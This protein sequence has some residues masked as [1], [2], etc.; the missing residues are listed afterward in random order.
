MADQDQSL[1]AFIIKHM[2]TDHTRSLSL[3]LRAYCTISSRASQSPT[4][5][6]I[7]L[8]DM[9]I[10]AQ[11]SR[12]TIPFDPPLQS[13]SETRA[14]VVAMHKDSL[15]RLGLSD[16]T[17]TEYVPPQGAQY[18]G[19]VIVLAAMVGYSRQGNFLPGALLYESVGLARFP[20]FTE[21][22]YKYQPWVIGALVV[23]HSFE[24]AVL[25]GW[26]RLR[27]HGVRLFS[28]LWWTWILLGFLEGA[29]AWRRFDKL[30]K[31]KEEGEHAKAA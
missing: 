3:Y 15:H 9:V 16:I 18:I 22:S 27:K 7:R 6:D 10:S 26:M 21:L 17:V 13:L 24:A 11:G 8:T 12:Y 30:V 19:F 25:L 23:S 4:L 29:P 2:N 28:G 14:R 31:E 5:E 1:K 20:G